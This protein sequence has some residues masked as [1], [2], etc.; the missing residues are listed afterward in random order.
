MFVVAFRPGTEYRPLLILWIKL[1]V[2][3]FGVRAWPYL[4]LLL[5]QYAA[6]LGL[7]LWLFRPAG[8]ARRVAAAI[9]ITCLVGLHSS[10]AMLGL[11]PVNAPSMG[12]ILVLLGA[13]LALRGHERTRE[14]LFLPLTAAALLL[15]ESGVVLVPLVLVL[16]IV[17]AP[18]LSWRSAAATLVVAAGYLIVRRAGGGGLPA[19]YTETGLGFGTPTLEQL[20]RHLH[21]MTAI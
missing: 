2:D 7:L 16:L 3:L 21:H 19:V 15:L 13:V 4:V 5:A 10:R 18:G 20:S 11:V 12:L 17:K 1:A 8:T 9:A 6:V 14:W